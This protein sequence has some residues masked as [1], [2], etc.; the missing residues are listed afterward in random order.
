MTLGETMR[1]LLVAL[2]LILTGLVRADI[3]AYPLEFPRDHAAHFENTP[4]TV[5]AYFLEWWYFSGEAEAIDGE[6]ISF[7]ISAFKMAAY[8]TDKTWYLMG[9]TEPQSG[10][11]TFVLPTDVDPALCTVS[12]VD[13]SVNYGDKVSIDRTE[14][15]FGPLSTEFFTI[16][17]KG[18]AFDGVELDYKLVLIPTR[19][20]LLHGE[21]GIIDMADGG[22]S[23]YYSNTRMRTAGIIKKGD[24]KFILKPHK[25]MTWFDHQWGDFMPRTA[26]GWEWF[27]LRLDNGSDIMVFADTTSNPLAVSSGNVTFRTADGSVEYLNLD[28]SFAPIRNNSWISPFTGFEYWMNYLLDFPELG[29]TL[30]ISSILDNQDAGGYEGGV[31]ALGTYQGQPITGSGAIEVLTAP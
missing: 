29:L 8:G 5:P 26:H 16:K 3:P 27:G 13:L 4:Y 7:Y 23:Y 12:S 24:K 17:A 31:T 30:D 22:N 14:L 10:N 21:D 6:K 20:P 18:T 2:L 9:L 28:S 15:S 19:D 1:I 11:Y 25:S